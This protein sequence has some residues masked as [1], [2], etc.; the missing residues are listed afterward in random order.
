MSE[1]L[2]L[3]RFSRCVGS[4]VP[5]SSCEWPS[6]LAGRNEAAVA[7]EMSLSSRSL[8]F[9]RSQLKVPWATGGTRRLRAR[10][11]VPSWGAFR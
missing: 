1:R 10:D 8:T 4:V 5:L 6:P 2:Q 11:A 9:V 7:V 3:F